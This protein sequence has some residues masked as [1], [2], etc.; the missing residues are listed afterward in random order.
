LAG[1]SLPRAWSEHDAAS[2]GAQATMP[3]QDAVQIVPTACGTEKVEKLSRP[4]TQGCPRSLLL[5]FLACSPRWNDLEV[6]L[7]H[8]CQLLLQSAIFALIGG[9][10]FI[11][12]LALL[13]NATAAYQ[14]NLAFSNHGKDELGSI[15]MDMWST[16]PVPK[17]S[18]SFWLFWVFC[19]TCQ[20]S[21]IYGSMFVA[22]SRW[23]RGTCAGLLVRWLPA[24]MAAAASFSWQ[25]WIINSSSQGSL[26]YSKKGRLLDILA[27][28]VAWLVSVIPCF[29]MCAPSFRAFHRIC[30]LSS[31]LAIGGAIGWLSVTQTITM[32]WSRAGTNSA[33]LLLVCACGG[34]RIVRVLI[35]HSWIRTSEQLPQSNNNMRIIML[36]ALNVMILTGGHVLQF[37]SPDFLSLIWVHATMMASETITNLGYMRCK[38][39]IERWSLIYDSCARWIGA[40]R[41]RVGG[42]PVAPRRVSASPP[43][44]PPPSLPTAWEPPKELPVPSMEDEY[45]NLRESRKELFGTMVVLSNYVEICTL[46][47]TTL[48]FLVCKISTSPSSR[49]PEQWQ[50]T[51]SFFFVALTFEVLGD[52]LVMAFANKWCHQGEIVA[53]VRAKPDWSITMQTMALS[54]VV[55]SAL[56]G[57]VISSLSLWRTAAEANSCQFRCA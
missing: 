29:A 20:R 17:E 1:A 3:W 35:T 11:L 33:R 53:P 14:V 26:H 39:E 52:A 10:C 18:S 51:V 48:L 4:E 57:K 16:S 31:K 36:G 56:L 46:S 54:A 43:D 15:S 42:I 5:E 28:Y 47:L 55:S 50:R 8:S 32:Y 19:F 9:V 2:S 34:L 49:R 22:A 12:P 7:H 21:F 23:Y 38:T 30:L 45:T 13:T 41:K 25:V 37:Q 27:R 40:T 24:L 6:G 44:Q